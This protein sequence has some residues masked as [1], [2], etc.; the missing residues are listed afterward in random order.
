M[1]RGQGEKRR[2][3][4]KTIREAGHDVLAVSEII[5]RAFHLQILGSEP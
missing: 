3:H 2:I 5:P 1:A 4:I